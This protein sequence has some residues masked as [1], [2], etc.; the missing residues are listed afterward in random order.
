MESTRLFDP[1]T[2]SHGVPYELIAEMRAVA[3]VQW[4]EE[5]SVMGWEEG[6]GYWAVLT[7]EC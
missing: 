7:H 3:P 2:Y 4:I 1:A 5:P 6:P